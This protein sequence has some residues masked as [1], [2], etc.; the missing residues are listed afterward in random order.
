MNKNDL[1]ALQ[2]REDLIKLLKK[3]DCEISGS[4][5]DDGYMSL[6][7]N[8]DF[9]DYIMQGNY[10][11]YNIVK[12]HCDDYRE[13]WKDIMDTYILNCFSDYSRAMAGLNNVKV[14]T[15]IFTN[16]PYK[17]KS[18]L[19]EIYD[20]TDKNNIDVFV[21]S[22]FQKELRLLDGTRYI[23]IKPIDNSRG[24]RCANAFIDRE[25]TL[26]ELNNIVFPIC[27][28]CSKNTVEVF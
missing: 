23:W 17:A 13:H 12:V 9:G 10:S 11:N 18:K 4:H 16:N 5:K 27:V 8:F 19:Q 22:K 7:F 3:H 25:L 6:E 14:H 1:K 21:L 26:E 2:F 28:Y 24:Y 20:K 15:G